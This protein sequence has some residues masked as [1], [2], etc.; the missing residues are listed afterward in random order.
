M[1]RIRDVSLISYLET[2]GDFY[3][4]LNRITRNEV[5]NSFPDFLKYLSD[6]GIDVDKEYLVWAK[7]A[8]YCLTEEVN[9]RSLVRPVL[10][11]I[12][13]NGSKAVLRKGRNR[14]MLILQDALGN[15][16]K[17]KTVYDGSSDNEKFAKEVEFLTEKFFPKIIE[18]NRKSPYPNKPLW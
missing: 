8:K 16:A 12:R 11:T 17:I 3:E 2:R 15:K 1:T 9:P 18:A 4:N 5:L 7:Y 13:K 14:L 10:D 6:E